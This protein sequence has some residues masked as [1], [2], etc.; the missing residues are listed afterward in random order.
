MAGE[1]NWT[2]NFS[3]EAAEVDGRAQTSYLFGPEN[4]LW[5]HRVIAVD[6]NGVEHSFFRE[7]STPVESM[8]LFTSTFDEVPLSLVKEFRLQVTPSRTLRMKPSC[9]PPPC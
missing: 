8:S 3:G 4:K 5:M 9:G 7:V 1:P 2:V 6:T